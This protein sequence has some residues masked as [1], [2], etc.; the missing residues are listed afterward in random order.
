[1]VYLWCFMFYFWWVILRISVNFRNNYRFP[2]CVAKK[3]K[4]DLIGHSHH[5]WHVCVM[6][7]MFTLYIG[8][9]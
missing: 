2:N 4:F 8:C 5:Y 1:M 9:L 7:G 6:F 3:G